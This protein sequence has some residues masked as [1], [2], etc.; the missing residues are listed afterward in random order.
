MRGAA[1]IVAGVLLA[2]YC[3]TAPGPVCGGLVVLAAVGL[4]VWGV[5]LVAGDW[6]R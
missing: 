2:A 5:Q 6:S 3:V 4:V 1:L